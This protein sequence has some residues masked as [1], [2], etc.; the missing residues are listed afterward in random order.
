MGPEPEAKPGSNPLLTDELWLRSQFFKEVSRFNSEL[1]SAK[2]KLLQE[3]AAKEARKAMDDD[4]DS[5]ASS[6]DSEQ[7]KKE[8]VETA[9]A[10]P[11]SE[12]VT[13]ATPQKAAAETQQS[14]EAGST[15]AKGSGK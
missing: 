6:S 14:G 13:E 9:A 15:A 12:G 4:R 7:E 10:E 8:K 5:F 2:A 3:E 11:R 1:E